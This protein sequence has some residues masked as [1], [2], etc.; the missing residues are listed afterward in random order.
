MIGLY[1]IFDAHVHFYSNSYFKYL[2]KQ[3]PNRADINTELRNLAAKGHI[4]IPGE[5]S[6]QLAK[7]WI[8]IIDKWKLERLM[9]F[10][11]IPG[12]EDSVVKA[13]QTHPTRFS[14]MFAVDPNSNV[15]IENATKRMKEDKLLGVLLYPSLYHINVNDDWLYPLY[16]LVQ[17]CRGIVFTHFGKLIMRPRDYADIPLVINEEFSNPKDLISIAKKFTGIKF[18]IPNFGAGKFTETLE[19]GKECSNVYVDTAGSNSW[20]SEHSEKLDLRRIFQKFL[21]VF[22]ANRILFGSDS[23]L[24]PRGYRYDIVDNQ[25]K[26]LQEMRIPMADIKK[27]FYENMAGLVDNH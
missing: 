4:E 25:L 18:I 27:I 14:G 23:G 3:K 17:E 11:S 15:L 19:V 10:G 1:K 8:D 13:V 5:D 2:V 24:L 6:T 26:L 20:I 16:N 7:R 22:T 9:L 12:D 21:E